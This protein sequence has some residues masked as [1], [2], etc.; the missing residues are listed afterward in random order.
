MASNVCCVL[1]LVLLS[2]RLSRAVVKSCCPDWDCPCPG[3]TSMTCAEAHKAVMAMS[4]TVHT[5]V[6]MHQN[7]SCS[8]NYVDE[9]YAGCRCASLDECQQLC[10]L[11][12]QC[13]GYIYKLHGAPQV[14]QCLLKNKEPK[15]ISFVVE[16]TIL[17]VTKRLTCNPDDKSCEVA[18]EANQIAREAAVSNQQYSETN[19]Q[20]AIAGSAIAGFAVLVAVATF[21]VTWKPT[22]VPTVARQWQSFRNANNSSAAASV[23]AAQAPGDN[24]VVV[25]IRPD[26]IKGANGASA[27]KGTAQGV[28]PCHAKQKLP[29]LGMPQVDQAQAAGLCSKDDGQTQVKA[30]V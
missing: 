30:W 24:D 8:V 18:N 2:L 15:K 6:V 23:P 13:I 9:D 26:S 14:G 17:Y 10:S 19:R 22:L 29:V 16:G 3:A 4:D 12:A 5:W 11:D 27:C 1:L 7:L 25:S 20:L 21:I 28:Q